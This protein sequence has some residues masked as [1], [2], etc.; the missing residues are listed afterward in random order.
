MKFKTLQ[1]LLFGD[2]NKPVHDLHKEET[3]ED[4]WRNL[5]CFIQRNFYIIALAFIL[6]SFLVFV[7]VCFY[8][9]GI[10]ATESGMMRNF[11]NGGFV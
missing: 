6:L 3:R 8:I 2:A 4:K 7:A 1:I 5:N 9:C 10:S 11:V